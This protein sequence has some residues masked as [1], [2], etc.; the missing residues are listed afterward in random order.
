MGGSD[1]LSV[2]P[3]WMMLY[4]SFTFSMTCPMTTLAR[5][6]AVLTDTR[7]TVGSDWEDAILIGSKKGVESCRAVRRP[8]DREEA[9][10]IQWCESRI[11]SGTGK[12]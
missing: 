11:E 1:S 6:G 9:R 12:K 10:I 3:A 2:L 5:S 8:R 7:R 4:L